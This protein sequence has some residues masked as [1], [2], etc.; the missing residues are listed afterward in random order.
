MSTVSTPDWVV[1]HAR[2][3]QRMFRWGERAHR[4]LP[5]R[6]HPRASALIG[7]VFSPELPQAVKIWSA[8]QQFTQCSDAQAHEWLARWLAN[9]GALAIELHDYPQLDANWARHEVHCSEGERDVLAD[10]AARGG[11]VITCH[12]HHHNR[13]GAFLGVS[14]TAVWGIA[15]PEETSL[16]QPW[17]ARYVRK[18]NGGSEAHFGG[19]RYLF[20]DDM[21]GLLRESRAALQRGETVVNLADGPQDSPTAVP[22]E[23]AGRRLD[24]ARALIDLA[25]DVGAPVRFAM[26]YSD[27]Q[28]RHRCR[29]ASASPNIGA[30]DVAHEYAAQLMRWCADEPYAWQ[31]FAWW[32]DLPFIAEPGAALQARRADAQQR[33]AASRPSPTWALRAMHGLGSAELRF[34]PPQP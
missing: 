24:M 5:R 16:W 28:G 12:S 1:A 13:L 10:I 19:G 9:Q 15:G 21:R 6:L 31:G 2:A 18:I 32:D 23:L 3:Q 4:W 17:T 8:L 20:I 29:L 34:A 30:G 26:F 7:Q 11:L 33:F 27:L 14:G 25:V 22:V